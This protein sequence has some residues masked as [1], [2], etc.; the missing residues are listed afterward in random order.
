ME[1]MMQKR[2]FLVWLSFTILVVSTA[3]G[4]E[5][6][7][8][9]GRE[10]YFCRRATGPVRVDG[11]L[12]EWTDQGA[13]PMILVKHENVAIPS[14]RGPDDA[15]LI[16][17][18]LWDDRNLYL[19][20]R[21]S[22]DVHERSETLA[23]MFNSD[24]IQIAFDPLDDTALPGYD[25]NDIEVGL[26]DSKM[27]VGA[28]CFN[29]GRTG[30]SGRVGSDKMVLTYKP[31]PNGKG[32]IYEAAISWDMIKPFVSKPGAHFGFDIIYND[33]D[34]NSEGRRGW[35]MWTP[36]IGE[37]KLS[38]LFRDVYLVGP[39]EGRAT[40]VLTTDRKYYE[41]GQKV[42]CY[43]YIP[44]SGPAGTAAQA[45]LV[46]KDGS[47]VIASESRSFSLRQ[48]V[49]RIDFYFT[50][51]KASANTLSAELTVRPAGCE[52]MVIKVPVY[53][54]SVASL[55]KRAGEI[56]ER[57]KALRRL[58]AEAGKAGV[59]TTYPRVTAATID[60][61]LK[62]RLGDLKDENL[63]KTVQ[64]LVA[65]HRQF[66]FLTEAADRAQREVRD[67]MA[68]PDHVKKLPAI[69][70]TD[71]VIKKG[72]F[73]KGDQPVMMFGPMGWLPIYGDLDLIAEM[74]FNTIGG[75]LTPECVIPA[76]GQV[77]TDYLRTIAAGFKTARQFNLA[78]DFLPSPHPVPPGW[79]KVYPD[80]KKYPSNGWMGTSLYQ[81]EVRRM[82]EEFW[83]I[84][85]PYLVK[86]PAL[87]SWDV[88]NE[89]EFSDGIGTIHPLMQSRFYQHL[90]DR[91]KDVGALNRVWKTSYKDFTAIDPLKLRRD[92]DVG[93]FYDWESFRHMEAAAALS[94][95]KSVIRRYDAKTPCHVKIIAGRDFGAYNGLGADRETVDDVMD[96]CGCDCGGP[97]QYDLYKSLHPSKPSNDTEVHLSSSYTAEEMRT[98]VWDSFLHGQSQRLMFAWANSYSAEMM[99]AG[100]VLHIPWAMEAAGR[101]ALD[102][103]RLAGEIVRFQQAIPA[104][105]VA[106]LFSPATNILDKFGYSA[107]LMSTHA[108]LFFLDTPV[109][110]ISERQVCEGQLKNV[111]V[112]IV[113]GATFVTDGAYRKILEYAKGGG[114]VYASPKA[115]SRD[116]YNTLRDA[117]ETVAAGIKR[118]HLSEP[119]FAAAFDS[120]FDLCRIS[121]PVRPVGL[122]GK[123]LSNIECRVVE[124]GTGHLAYLI[125]HG[126]SQ[127]S[128]TLK[129]DRKIIR[130]RELISGTEVTLPILVKPRD[131]LMLR[132]ESEARAGS[133]GSAKIE[134]VK[135]S[136]QI[137]LDDGVRLDYEGSPYFDLGGTPD[138]KALGGQAKH[139]TDKPGI[140]C[141]WPISV[142]QQLDPGTYKVVV[143]VRGQGTLG[144]G[145]WED[146]TNRKIQ[147]WTR[148]I[149]TKTYQK[150]EVGN[151][152]HDGKVQLRLADWSSPGLWFDYV[153]V[154]PLG[155]ASLNR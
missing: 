56:S 8:G 33:N 39:K 112:L 151:F 55:R 17:Y 65:F 3:W 95:L 61:C 48:D 15:S 107:A 34:A 154:K 71:I 23:G 91:Y 89:W 9:F 90:R 92:T 138:P 59:D 142:H 20:A 44:W 40:P 28:Y 32:G 31:L 1:F 13:L 73:Y 120:I 57:N 38:W 69:E 145:L 78:V 150:I 97:I 129:M 87:V 77:R 141:W 47:K 53:D 51:G 143:R 123:R 37:E 80:M 144:M 100:A 93:G 109:R 121:R 62:Y 18:M 111:R 152:D 58:I 116:P 146:G 6:H 118:Y 81:P 132:I 11:D 79:L 29:G 155:I 46:V 60:V 99:V 83:K 41:A 42:G 4:V 21:V 96:I 136:D 82:V 125:N 74:G 19:A 94:F 133:E 66:E 124:E 137:V 104:G 101:T 102:L 131:P 135:T 113:P 54:L 153:Y 85:V 76:P 140:Y 67:L 84:L 122:D 26:A 2:A 22:D 119:R 110:F 50:L 7:V 98:S 30:V 134:P 114:A 86:E 128:V 117:G 43:G 35:I 64:P 108:G 130:V 25:G 24:S 63:I 75:T 149:N 147:E 70:M 126:S 127:V 139:L 14:W 16:V 27:G 106:I 5:D 52:V 115:L 12:K 148:S 88:V 103:R 36:G 68:H 105:P 49:N 45:E 10:D 72:S